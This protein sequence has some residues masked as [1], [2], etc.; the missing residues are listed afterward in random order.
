MMQ[1]LIISVLLVAAINAFT[2]FRTDRVIQ[3]TKKPYFGHFV[4]SLIY[5]GY[6]L[7]LVKSMKNIG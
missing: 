3:V 1:I 4:Q 6:L 5:G 2:N 7:N